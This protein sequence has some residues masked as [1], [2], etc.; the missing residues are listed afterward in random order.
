MS[1]EPEDGKKHHFPNHSFYSIL[2]NRTAI[3]QLARPLKTL[4]SQSGPKI[5]SSDYVELI[6]IFSQQ[7][8]N[9]LFHIA[10]NITGQCD[11]REL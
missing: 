8:L 7:A 5:L 9:I 2:E 3:I 1:T 4:Q 6:L 10:H 11:L